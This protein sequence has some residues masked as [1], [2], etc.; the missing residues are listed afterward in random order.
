MW[1][2]KFSSLIAFFEKLINLGKPDSAVA[3]LAAPPPTAARILL[4]LRRRG[5]VRN[6][7]AYVM[8]AIMNDRE[9]REL[10]RHLLDVAERRAPR[11]QARAVIH[12]RPHDV[13]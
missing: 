12:D 2:E 6:P 10:A 1:Q 5:G 13:C 8:R 11:V 7:S 3:M 4:N 9:V